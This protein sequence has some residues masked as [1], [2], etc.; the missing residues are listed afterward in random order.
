MRL[1]PLFVCLHS[2]HVHVCLMRVCVTV[3]E[4]HHKLCNAQ[5]GMLCLSLCCRL[6]AKAIHS[7]C[8]E[9]DGCADGCIAIAVFAFHMLHA[10]ASVTNL[11]HR[12]AVVIFMKKKLPQAPLTG[13]SHSLASPWGCSRAIL[14]NSEFSSSLYQHRQ[15]AYYVLDLD[16]ASYD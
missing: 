11:S 1:F 9:T 7:W 2:K 13:A 14:Q 15:G 6:L 3:H 10:C 16:V 5:P 8:M 4:L 12:L